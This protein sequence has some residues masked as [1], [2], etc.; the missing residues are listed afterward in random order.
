MTLLGRQGTSRTRSYRFN[1]LR[2]FK[3]R[4]D[5]EVGRL[6]APFPENKLNSKFLGLNDAELDQR[7]AGLALWI[8]EFLSKTAPSPL[9]LQAAV[10]LFQV[11][12]GQLFGHVAVGSA[13]PARARGVSPVRGNGGH[14]HANNSTAGGSSLS[15]GGKVDKPTDSSQSNGASSP[16]SSSTTGGDPPIKMGY[17]SKEGHVVR[18]IKKRFFVLYPT[19]GKMYYFESEQAHARWSAAGG[20]DYGDELDDLGSSLHLSPRLSR[21][22]S[23]ATMRSSRV[24]G[25]GFGIRESISGSEK[26][27]GCIDLLGVITNKLM[28]QA[29]LFFLPFRMLL[30]A[31]CVYT[32]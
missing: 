25:F 2:A 26:P 24:G 15:S 9:L 11:D 22:P 7:A 1:V 6:Q 27:K 18:S 5:N 29:C 32:L 14:G 19:K 21:Q 16:E 20:A 30:G 10:H 8:N 4:V 28:I 23:E 12:E 17:L 13:P 31:I 3:K